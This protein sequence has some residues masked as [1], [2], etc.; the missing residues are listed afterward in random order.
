[1]INELVPRAQ[2]REEQD[3]DLPIGN[4]IDEEEKN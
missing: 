3:H 1:M 2:A 4:M